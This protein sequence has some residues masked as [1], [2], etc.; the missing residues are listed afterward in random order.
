M[1]KGNTWKTGRVWCHLSFL[2]CMITR[3]SNKAFYVRFAPCSHEHCLLMLSVWRIEWP[4]AEDIN[5]TIVIGG[6]VV[7]EYGK[8][9]YVKNRAC[10]MS[11]FVFDDIAL[12]FYRLTLNSVMTE[13]YHKAWNF[14]S[15][16]LVFSLPTV[17]H[18]LLLRT[19]LRQWI[20]FSEV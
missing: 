7:N 20:I 6:S 9:K 19:T 16:Y 17:T 14:K 5:K 4:L 1:A 18:I 2:M 3:S 11:S 10:L 12:H 13:D 8:R 15:Q